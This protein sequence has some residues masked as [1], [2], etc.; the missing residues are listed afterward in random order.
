MCRELWSKETEK[1]FFEESLKRFSNPEKLFY[2][3]NENRY[4]AYWP[5]DYRGPKYTLQSRNSLIGQFT[6][7]WVADLVNKIVKDKKL[8]AVQG[9]VCEE[10]GLNRRSPGDVVISK[11][12]APVLDYSDIKLI[13]E[14]KMSIVWNWEYD[15]KMGRVKCIGDFRSHQ[16][17]P[18]LLRSDSMLKAIGKCINI[19]VS[20]FKAAN[21]PL[22]IIGNT[23]ISNNYYSKVDHLK[24]S[25]II[26]GFWSLNPRPLDDSD[27]IKNT[28]SGGFYRFDDYNE[29]KYSF[30]RLLKKEMNFFS[31]MK[32]KKDLGKIIEIANKEKTYEK[33]AEVFLNMIRKE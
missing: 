12:K 22:L 6:E 20:G 23:P 33:K 3:T 21:I 18:S 8:Y 31:S 26:Q 7:K 1:L 28:N 17:N 32:T 2:I 4:V 19:R 30:D 9:A 24:R 29:L 10:I 15:E 25:G 5:K 14:V 16:A 13:I 11:K 27:T